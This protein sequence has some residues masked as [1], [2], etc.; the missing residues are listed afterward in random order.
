MGSSRQGKFNITFWKNL[1][2][3][4]KLGVGLTCLVIGLLIGVIG[5]IAFLNYN[6]PDN[7]NASTAQILSASV[8]FERIQAENEIVG[9]SQRYNIVEKST[10][11]SSVETFVGTFDIPFTE[12]SFW[13]RYIGIIKAGVSLADATYTTKD[14]G[15]IVISLP[16]PYI[17]SN[18]PDM[19]A[20]GVL[21]EHNNIFNPIHVE[22][23]D[24]FQRQCIKKSTSETVD[25][26]L[27]D[28]AK[29]N[30]EAN[31]RGVFQGA[32]GSDQQVE[33]EWKDASK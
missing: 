16:Q 21:E 28:E 4:S 30:V 1:K 13:Y 20:S 18:T 12:N 3:K 31:I 29:A 8:V 25:N 5:H 33:F 17:I 27:Y 6:P 32:F 19:D 11:K 2:P 22:D 24:S 7:D 15:T 23:V 10:S 9:A 14:N 26:G